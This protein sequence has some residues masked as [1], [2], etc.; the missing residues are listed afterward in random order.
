MISSEKM[1]G[2]DLVAL[3][4]SLNT[5]NARE[6]KREQNDLVVIEKRRSRR[7]CTKYSPAGTAKSHMMIAFLFMLRICQIG[8]LI[9]KSRVQVSHS[10][11]KSSS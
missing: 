9:D 7:K 5:E 10:K 3:E 6:S 4:K 8:E 11:N 2:Q 1:K